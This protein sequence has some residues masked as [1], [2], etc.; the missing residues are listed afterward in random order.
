MLPRHVASAVI[1]DALLFVPPA[2]GFAGPPPGSSPHDQITAEAAAP[3]GFNGH[4]L[5]ALQQAV[6]LPDLDAT[7]VKASGSRLYVPDAS[8]SY[9]PSHSCDRAPPN[10]PAD[11]FAAI[12]ACAQRQREEERQFAVSGH[13]DRAVRALG[14]ALHALQDCDSHS[15]VVD[16]GLAPRQAFDPALLTKGALRAGIKI[17]AFQRGAKIAEMPAGDSYPHGVHNQDAPNS[18]DDAARMLP[19]GQTKYFAA[20]GL[21]ASA[22]STFLPSFM[23]GLTAEQQAAILATSPTSPG[24]NVPLLPE[25]KPL[26]ILG[27]GV[28]GLVIGPLWFAPFAFGRTWSRRL[29]D[30]DKEGSRWHWKNLLLAAAATTLSAY[31]LGYFV[32]FAGAVTWLAGAGVGVLA[33]LAFLVFLELPRGMVQ[34]TPLRSVLDMG[35]A[36]VAVGIMGAILGVWG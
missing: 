26:G 34:R 13:A 11:A 2:T 9:P 23:P 22:S 16:H 32:P 20:Q 18:T 35:H 36:L 33:W 31:L 4:S 5:Q 1:L 29:G 3:L 7:K 17:G 21:A 30:S 25:V 27:G 6:R 8:P 12:A 28:A 19:E 24:A 10:S 15:D 14:N